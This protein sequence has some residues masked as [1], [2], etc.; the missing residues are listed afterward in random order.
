MSFE[1]RADDPKV[2][3]LVEDAP[4]EY[5]GQEFYIT[6]VIPYRDREGIALY[7]V[8]AEA[9]FMK[10][11]DI[12]RVG[13]FK[14]SGMTINDG[15][16]AI[17]DGTGWTSS[18]TT[19]MDPTT[20][21]LEATDASILDLVYQWAK[22]TGSEVQLG[23]LN[24]EIGMGPFVGRLLP[25]TFRY[26]RNVKEIRRE[27]SPPKVTRLYAYG[28]NN[29]SIAAINS[30]L[31]YIED[32]SFYTDAGMTLPEAQARYRKDQ[33][34]RD[35]S[36]IEDTTLKAAAE[37]RLAILS[38]P[39]VMYKASVIDLTRLSG[40][41]E[42]YYECGDQVHVYDEILG[43]AVD[44]RVSRM[45]RYPNNPSL[46]EIELTFNPFDTL[47]PNV[48]TARDAT[49]QWEL[50]ESRNRSTP[51]Q[52][53]QG[54]Q[55]A[56]RIRLNT[57]TD[58]EWVLGFKLQGVGVGSSTVTVT[59]TQD[60]DDTDIWTPYVFSV[61][62][63]QVIDLNFTL[64]EK[65]IPEGA[66][67]IVVRVSSSVAGAGMDV[68]A[69]DTT[70][71]ALARGATR[72]QATLPNSITFEY[73]GVVQSF[74]V[75]DDVTEI[76][77]DALGAGG[78]QGGAATAGL[79]GLVRGVMAVVGGT[80]YDVYVGGSPV[81]IS[82]AGWPNGGRAN[83]NG[84]GGGGST[85]LVPKGQ[86]LTE[87]VIVA[88]GGGGGAHNGG[89]VPTGTQSKGGDGGFYLGATGGDGG[90]PLIGAE[91]RVGGTGASQTAGGVAGAGGNGS[92]MGQNGSF[93]QGGASDNGLVGVS[94]A[95]GGGGGG[96]YGGAGGQNGSPG[97]GAGG[98]SGWINSE[99]YDLEYVDADNNSDGTMTISWETPDNPDIG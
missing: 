18:P 17:L 21:A 65:E 5:E 59:V 48:S 87:A 95:G 54:S 83:D 64:G 27:S 94:S 40:M 25:L 82:A 92:G 67:T 53:R 56:H 90:S 58:A 43:F 16:N 3:S 45:V 68:A 51:R 35:D 91:P 11:A 71:W 96:W 30:G 10:L 24:K 66:H 2:V 31:S 38:Q 86:A 76:Y 62:N 4:L 73:T 39:T 34:W 32:Y 74:T 93:M 97:A 9:S 20:F 99:I 26:G 28:R 52:F 70:L 22:I 49:Q 75:P 60:E 88:P 81:T 15:L 13:S 61:V 80:E 44:A 6:K 37:A 63:G 46:D 41:R 50:F 78:A 72:S 36:F 47:D 55:V 42:N 23:T 8:E 12:L 85:H 77:I 14:I 29:L 19:T 57:V 89:T 79:G 1:L 69:G 7:M 33:M 84:G 98:G